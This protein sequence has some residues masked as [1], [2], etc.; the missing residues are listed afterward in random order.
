ML[1][2]QTGLH[3]ESTVQGLVLHA[4]PEAHTK[5]VTVP[6]PGIVLTLADDAGAKTIEESRSARI[7][8][9]K[10]RAAKFCMNLK[11]TLFL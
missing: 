3:V 6:P 9:R 4:Y 7:V 5:K 2:P 8:S 11:G 10:R 1:S